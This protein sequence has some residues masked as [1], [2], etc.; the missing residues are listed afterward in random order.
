MRKFTE[1]ELWAF[2]GR[3][4]SHE[5]VEIASKFLS[6]LDYLSNELLDALMDSLAYTS[7]ELYH[8]EREYSAACPWNAPGMSAR[9]FVR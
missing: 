9:D 1:S 6:R 8:E 7:R 4:D 3:A 2:V 5:R